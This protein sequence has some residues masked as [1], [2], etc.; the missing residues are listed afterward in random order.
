MKIISKPPVD[1]K[2]IEL[3]TTESEPLKNFS[4]NT[5]ENNP[6]VLASL[7]AAHARESE[8]IVAA[9]DVTKGKRGRTEAESDAAK[10]KGKRQKVGAAS[11]PKKRR[12]KGECIITKE[13]LDKALDGIKAEEHQS[14]KKKQAPAPIFTPMV[15]VIADMKKMAADEAD[16]MLAEQKE[17]QAKIIQ[18]REAKLKEVGLD[19]NEDFFVEKMAEVK[20][21]ADKTAEIAKK[22]VTDSESAVLDSTSEANNS[23][24]VCQIPDPS[25]PIS[26]SSSQPPVP[27]STQ[28]NSVLDNLIRHCSGE[29]PDPNL[30]S[31]KASE[32]TSKAVASHKVVS[33]SPKQHTPEPQKTSSPQQQ[34]TNMH[35]DPQPEQTS[36]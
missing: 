2:W 5:Q 12:G 13:Q 15:E 32:T 28:D 27:E 33:E 23:V 35:I 21:I 7:V 6:D 8:A 18:D 11:I 34:P 29:L 20:G 4:S 26:P 25:I 14:K 16:K 22:K 24:K 3:T 31:E 17:K 9:P 30:N 10:V 1:E 36:P 19:K